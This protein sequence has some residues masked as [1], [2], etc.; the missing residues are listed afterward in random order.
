M[1]QTHVFKISKC[2]VCVCVSAKSVCQSGEW[3]CSDE[4]CPGTCSVE[5]GAHINTFDGHI[6]TIHGDC[7]YILAKVILIIIWNDKA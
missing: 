3:T 5:G 2:R 6:Y 4:N 1:Y 7:N